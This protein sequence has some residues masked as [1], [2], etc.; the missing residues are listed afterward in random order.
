MKRRTFKI[1]KTISAHPF[2]SAAVLMGGALLA[3]LIAFVLL[4]YFISIPNIESFSEREVVESTKIYD[5]TGEILLWELH[6]EERRT[7]VPF[8]A[9]GR[10]VKNATV[11]IEDADFYRHPGVDIRGIMRAL[12]V[13]IISGEIKQGG[14]TITQQLVK[15]ALLNPRQTITRKIKEAIIALKLETVYSKD[16]ILSLYL[17]EIPYGSNAYG[18]ESAAQT[19]FGKHA[20]ELTLAE[21]AYIAAIANAP[22]RYSPYGNNRNLLEDRKNLVLSRMRDLHYLTD[23]EYEAGIKETVTFLAP[24]S[25]GIRAPHFVM[26]VRSILEEEFPELEVEQQGFKVITS[27]DVEMQARAEEVVKKYAE[28]NSKNFNA[29]NAGLVALEPSTGHILA[30]VGS[31]DYFDIERD[32]NY[33]VT[34]AHRQPGSSFKPIVYAASFE[35]GYTP[36]TVVFDL[37]TEFSTTRSSS[38]TP[39]NYDLKF[40]GPMTLR[41]ALAQS[42]NVPAVKVLYLTGMN[43]ALTLARKMGISTL[44]DP[45]RFGLSLVL[46]GG[47]VSPLELT[48]AYATFANNG[49]FTPHAAILKIETNTGSSVY[50]QEVTSTS[51][52]APS[53]VSAISSVL[54]DNKARTPMFGAQSPLYFS[55][56]DVAV[57]TGTSNDFRD[58]WTVGYS[59]GVVVGAWAGNNDNSPVIKQVAGFI[60]APLWREF[61]DFALT[62]YPHEAFPAY[63]PDPTIT[64]PV[65][66]GEWRGSKTYTVDR[67]SG[68]LATPYTPEDVREERIIQEIHDILHWVDK[69]DPRG[70]IPTNPA[71]DPQY[72]NWESPVAT[73][74]ATQNISNSTTIPT[75]TDNVHLPEYQPKG[76]LTNLPSGP[77]AEGSTIAVSLQTTA[78]YPIK[79]LDIFWDGEFI[80]SQTNNFTTISL[81]VPTAGD[82]A[83]QRHT[84]QVRIYD[85]MENRGVV[86]AVIETVRP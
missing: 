48:N 38:Y 9:I 39:Q 17:N 68:K 7:I 34:L 28:S 72:Q 3:G 41:D 4:F 42:I 60:V 84:L 74:A 36:E 75:E 52:L 69:D 63:A 66:K 27:L 73:W 20:S 11:A 77:V 62:K 81:D 85:T 21:S 58:S 83:S 55:S 59:S 31:R 54:S 14:S 18:I 49:A 47:E 56:G 35:K 33:N 6:G 76:A 22:T 61:M 1:K 8:D 43:N 86:E 29:T 19:F 25:R 51:V 79:H 45:S 82:D 10:N 80:K 57:K 53:T 13:D 78:K 71:A 40:R 5:R 46:G 70:P 2:L 23:E 37:P 16:E 44:T 67:I 50:E 24:S 30:M 64:K 26:Y 32:G 65:L 12:M 15:Y